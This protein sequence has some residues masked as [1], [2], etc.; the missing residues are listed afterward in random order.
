MFNSYQVFFW[1]SFDSIVLSTLYSFISL[2]PPTG[3]LLS[4]AP[5]ASLKAPPEV[6]S[7][8]PNPGMSVKARDRGLDGDEGG[9]AE[10]DC[11][12]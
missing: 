7:I 6:C 1:S 11:S 9:G 5:M 8:L 12:R 2:G 3:V 4:T 10:Q